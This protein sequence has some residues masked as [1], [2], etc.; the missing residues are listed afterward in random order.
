[1]LNFQK[2]I[3]VLTKLGYLPRDKAPEQHEEDLAKDLWTL[4]KGEDNHGVSF[5]TLRVVLLNIIGIRVRDREYEDPHDGASIHANG[6][7]GNQG[8]N[9]SVNIS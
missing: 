3:N 7:E 5:N 6:I 8:D 2:F 4:V 9:S 1:M